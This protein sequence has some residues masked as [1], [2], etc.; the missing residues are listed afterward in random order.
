M[1]QYPAKPLRDVPDLGLGESVDLRDFVD[2]R[3]GA[4]SN[5]IRDHRG[6]RGRAV[7]LEHG[8]LDRVP[9]VPREVDVDVGRILPLGREEALEEEVVTHRVDV[10]D[11]EE[12]GHDARRAGTPAA[13]ARRAGRDR[14][15]DEEVVGVALAADDRELAVEALAHLGRRGA[16]V[17]VEN[18]RLAARAQDFER[19]PAVEWVGREYGA[20]H[21]PV[22]RALLAETR[23]VLERLGRVRKSRLHLGGGGEGAGRLRQVV[24]G[25][26]VE[27]G[28]PVD[29]AEHVV[30]PVL[31]LV[32]EVDVV[33]RDAGD[34]RGPRPLA[35]RAVSTAGDE[36]GVDRQRVAERGQVRAILREQH[37][38]LRVRADGGRERERGIEMSR[39]EDTAKGAV[40][41]AAPRK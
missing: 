5:V 19:V 2:R 6:P 12:V 23:R 7:L 8:Q 9:L 37:E 17:A 24:R 25:D 26:A 14:L 36:L 32:D 31:L 16:A 20:P 29:R 22:D 30:K 38:P 11:A 28:V 15:H 27:R 39:G 18:P 21:R 4:E 33:R 3:L 40:T 35:E 1:P 13:R 34:A 10:G 41:F